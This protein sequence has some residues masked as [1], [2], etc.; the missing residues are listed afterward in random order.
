MMNHVDYEINKELGECYLFM[1]EYDKARDYYNKA[2]DCN[3]GMID[4]YLGLAAIAVHKGD[5]ADALALYKKAHRVSPGE[6][7]LA[8]M[9]MM[10]VEQ[11]SYEEAFE[12]FSAALGHNPGNM[13]AVNSLVQLGY[14]LNRLEAVLPHLE[15][16]L[17][18]GDTEAVRYAL[19]ACL[20][21]LGHENDA[22]RH[23]EILLGE[24]PSNDGAK[25]LYAQLA[26]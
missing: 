17:E 3:A 1:G 22:R 11:G 9:G 15:A 18:P 26:A 6:K 20:M 23:L 14:V 16:A 13:M 7:S 10:E 2:V 5:Y 12:H 25:Q 8:G 21:T 24:N 4:P 19:A